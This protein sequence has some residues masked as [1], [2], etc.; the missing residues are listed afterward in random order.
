MGL[1]YAQNIQNN[2]IDDEKDED[3]CGITLIEKK[4]L[5]NSNEKI[6]RIG[7]EFLVLNVTEITEKGIKEEEDE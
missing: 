6:R 2:N 1:G 5:S 3:G 7:F 4:L